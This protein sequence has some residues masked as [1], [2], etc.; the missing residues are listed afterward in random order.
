M[1][2]VEISESLVKTRFRVVVERRE[3]REN[4]RRVV[5][6]MTQQLTRGN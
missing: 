2:T 1:R 3:A 5:G 6:L 4:F